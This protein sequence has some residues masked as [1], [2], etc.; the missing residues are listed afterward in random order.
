MKRSRF[1]LSTAAAWETA[2]FMVLYLLVGSAAPLILAFGAGALILPVGLVMLMLYPE[3]YGVLLNLLRLGKM[4]A[5]IPL[6]L[7]LMGMILELLSPITGQQPDPRF[8][9]IMVILAV[10]FLFLVLLISYRK[11]D[12]SRSF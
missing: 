3:K 11:E 2:R 7:L 9:T 6:L 4:L 1:F 8:Y 12:E 10:D 5:I